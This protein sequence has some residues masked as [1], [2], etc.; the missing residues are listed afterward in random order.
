MATLNPAYGTSAGSIICDDPNIEHIAI[1]CRMN[2][3]ADRAQKALH[4]DNILIGHIAD[5]LKHPLGLSGNRSDRNS[6]SNSLLP[7]GIR[8]NN[9]LHIFNNVIADI[10]FNAYRQLMECFSRCCRCK[11]N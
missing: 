6:R 4:F 9:T 2:L 7:T 3:N 1:L 11:G 8:N 10:D 5:H